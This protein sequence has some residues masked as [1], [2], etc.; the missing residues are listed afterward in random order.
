MSNTVSETALINLNVFTYIQLLISTLY[1]T[2]KTTAEVTSFV[3]K[4]YST[5]NIAV[6]Y[7]FKTALTLPVYLLFPFACWSLETL[8]HSSSVACVEFQVLR[9]L[10]IPRCVKL[11]KETKDKITN[12][13][14]TQTAKA[15]AKKIF[16]K[17]PASNTFFKF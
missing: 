17:S 11:K 4:V 8:F 15:H 12:Y 3:Q 9:T 2:L 5:S 14:T 13:H 16:Q 7:K 10:C 6:I 1:T